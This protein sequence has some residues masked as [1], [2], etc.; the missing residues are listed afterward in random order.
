MKPYLTRRELEI[1]KLIAIGYNNKQIA[2]KLCVSLH[3]V[4]FHMENIF[5]K[6]NCHTRLEAVIASVRNNLISL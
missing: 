2:D 3:T 5:R 6:F 4:K 1:I